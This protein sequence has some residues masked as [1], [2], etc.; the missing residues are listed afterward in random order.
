MENGEEGLGFAA[1][2]VRQ[3]DSLTDNEAN[4]NGLFKGTPMSWADEILR[5]PIG[6]CRSP[7]MYLLYF[8]F[9]FLTS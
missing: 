5:R 6:Y 8:P 7:R 3:V 2:Y 1:E 9:H 4:G